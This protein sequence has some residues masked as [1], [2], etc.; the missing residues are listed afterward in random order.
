MAKT[1]YTDHGTH[2]KLVTGSILKNLT[3]RAKETYSTLYQEQ[4]QLATPPGNKAGKKRISPTFSISPHRHALSA[5]ALD[6]K[7]SQDSSKEPKG[8]LQAALDVGNSSNSSTSTTPVLNH[9]KGKCLTQPSKPVSNDGLD[10]AEGNLIV[11]ENDRISVPAAQVHTLEQGRNQFRVVSLLGQGT[12][13]Q[14]FKCQCLQTGQIVALKVVKN[15]PA[16]TRQAAVEIDVFTAL[17]GVENENMVGLQCYFLYHHH[18]CLVFELLGLNLY[19][20]LKRRQFRGLPLAIVRTLVQQAVEGVK[21]LTSK[22]IVHCDLKPENILLSNEEDAN[23]IVNAGEAQRLKGEAQRHKFINKEDLMGSFSGTPTTDDTGRTS[24]EASTQ[25]ESTQ[26][27]KLIDFGSACF[28]GHAAHTYIQSRFY[29]CPEILVGVP[30]DSAIDMWSMGCVAA[31]LF[32]GLPILPG[33]NEHDQLR[34][35]SEMIG[36]LPDR[37]LEQG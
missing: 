3:L 9:S 22:N 28:E 31:E 16:Y 13:A 20:V 18:L 14:V 21:D 10:N 25:F 26:K 11:Y 19:E 23:A 32:L 6:D 24:S 15:K 36:P 12:F 7:T 27:I 2:E 4:S 8:L 37:M 29:R 5:L 1:E 30:Y 34:R 35:I 33:V 17:A